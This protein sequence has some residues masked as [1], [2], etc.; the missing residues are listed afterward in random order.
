MKQK[1]TDLAYL[2]GII[3]GE[4]CINISRITRNN[5]LE[6]KARFNV[7]STDEVLIDWLQS[8]FK[9]YKYKRTTHLIK[10]PTWKIKYEWHLCFSKESVKLLK[11]IIPFL[12]IKGKQLEIVIEYLKTTLGKHGHKLTQETKDKRDI[13]YNILKQSKIPVAET[14]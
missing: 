3:D 12:V 8:H 1:Q 2:A 9:G 4:G 10:H 7:V 11:Q 14:E 13:L 6:Y 5:S